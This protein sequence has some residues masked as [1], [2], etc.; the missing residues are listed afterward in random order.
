MWMF[1]LHL[2]PEFTLA[3]DTHTHAHI[4]HPCVV[5]NT[6]YYNMKA[7][8]SPRL[9]SPAGITPQRESGFF[10]L[11]LTRADARVYPFC[12]FVCDFG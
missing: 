8:P 6:R 10:F 2:E 1:N 11:S 3:S 12:S 7:P 9:D 4:F 5:T